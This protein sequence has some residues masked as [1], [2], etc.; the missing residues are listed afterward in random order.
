METK[1]GRKDTMNITKGGR[2]TIII[3]KDGT[4]VE[5][6]E[7]VVGVVKELSQKMSNRR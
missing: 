6:E 7:V 5:E 1:D 2:D 4:E 3:I